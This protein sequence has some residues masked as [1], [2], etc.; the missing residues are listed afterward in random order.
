MRPATTRRLTFQ[1]FTRSSEQSLQ[2]L[3]KS[4]TSSTGRNAYIPLCSLGI[5]RDASGPRNVQGKL[6][7]ARLC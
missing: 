6:L 3:P 4:S 7:R 2:P 5:G 1:R